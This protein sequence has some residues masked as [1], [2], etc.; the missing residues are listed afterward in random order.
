ML[1][2]TTYA[3]ITALV[4]ASA[5]TAFAQSYRQNRSPASWAGSPFFI[6]TRKPRFLIPGFACRRTGSSRACS[7]SIKISG[8]PR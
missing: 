5:S 3:L 8:K 2:K 1:T 6:S 4:L 7:S